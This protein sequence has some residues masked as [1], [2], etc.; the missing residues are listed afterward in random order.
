MSGVGRL[1][2]VAL[3][4]A[5]LALAP[6]SATLA[7]ATSTT[8]AEAPGPDYDAWEK[9]ASRAE[10]AVGDPETTNARLDEVR[11]QIADWRSALLVAQSTNSSRIAT[12]RSQIQALGPA[13][14]EGQTEAAEIASRRRELSQQ[15]IKLQAPGIAADEAYRRADGVIR[16]IDRIMRERQA[17][18]FMKLWPA[19]VNPSNWPEGIKTLSEAARGL[20]SESAAAW[21]QPTSRT[22][23]KANLPLVVVLML[24]AAGLIWRG[25]RLT[26]SL[27]LRLQEKASARWRKIWGLLVSLGQIVL[28]TIGLAVLAKALALTSMLGPMGSGVVNLLPT[29][30]FIV[31]SAYW[32]AGRVFPKSAAIEAPL[33][34]SPERRAEGRLYTWSF[35]ALIGIDILLEAVIDPL[36]QSEASG[37]VLKFPVVALTGILL[38]R[39]GQLLRRHVENDA[40]SSDPRLFRS[41]LI[42]LAGRAAEVIGVAGP[43]LA[44]IGYVPGAEALVLPAAASLGLLGLI[45]VVQQFVDDLYAVLMGSEADEGGDLVPVL[46]GFAL[47]LGSVPLFALVWG[48][49]MADISELWARFLEGFS[50]G[51]TQISPRDFLVFLLIFGFGFMLTRF[52]Q[53]AL[54]S[55]L[56]PRTR[57]DQGA[58]TALL[59]GI[60]YAG[61]FLSALI[62]IKS[63]GINLSGLAIVA[64]ALSLGIGFG[65]Q[66]IV[67]NFVSGIILLVER[68]VSEGDWIEVGG[69]QGIVKAISVRSTRIQTF[70]RTDGIVPNADLV[71][72]PVTNWTRFNLSGRLVLPVA[73][74]HGSDTRQVESI[75]RE[76]AEAEPLAVLNPAPVIVFAGYTMDSM[77]FEI[78]VILRDVNFS[79]SVRSEMNHE[80][81]RRLREAGIGIPFTQR[82]TR[83]VSPAA[84]GPTLPA[85][86]DLASNRPA[87]HF[88]DEAPHSDASDA[89]DS[90]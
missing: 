60:G 55:S 8:S 76:I 80:V 58:Q 43:V 6:A 47:A 56:L 53:G 87:G 68:P 5:L 73:V 42:G 21:Q 44:A 77:N 62:A 2:R 81:V 79:L 35:A 32:L 28:P 36:R 13:P 7:Q 22:E 40:A 75:L 83:I 84:A 25:R 26:E 41:R 74:S 4:A 24:L 39:V 85:G 45:F 82:E 23:L 86:A 59:S 65:L 30:G 54:K 14:A 70:D 33:R 67:Q 20:W 3:A 57:L 27:S 49:R 10:K 63:A 64:G 90:R 48:T 69:V 11:T 52:L 46:I 66:N 15:L 71:S 61:I 12:L 29:V 1:I 89:E 16:E 18:Q 34:L 9:I 31:Y 37:S 78:R 88:R 50:I 51:E 19:P 38:F 72:N 17:D